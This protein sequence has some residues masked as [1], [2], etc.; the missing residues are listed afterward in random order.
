MN[1]FRVS[2][3]DR[4][5]WFCQRVV[6]AVDW[7]ARR[8]K[9][10]WICW[11][12]DRPYRIKRWLQGARTPRLGVFDVSDYKHTTAGSLCRDGIDIS[13]GGACPVQGYGS[14]WAVRRGKLQEF[15]CYYRSRAEGW[16][17][18]VAATE[19][20]ILERDIFEYS[21]RPYA[22]PDGGW[23]HWTVTEACILRAVERFR[24]HCRREVWCE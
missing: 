12:I 19:D 22:F 9:Q 5:S 8:H 18:H 11:L 1:T 2:L 21:E 10:R 16:Q 23:V 7:W 4:F 3:F 6:S 15:A 13:W 14:V 20:D 17:F 24:E